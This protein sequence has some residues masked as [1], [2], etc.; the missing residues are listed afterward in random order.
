VLQP[1]HHLG[2]VVTRHYERLSQLVDGEPI[3]A[4]R[5]EHEDP[6]TDVR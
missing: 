4:Y 3:V 5:T 1:L 2:Q 6:K